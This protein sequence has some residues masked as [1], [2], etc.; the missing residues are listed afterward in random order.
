MVCLMA[1]VKR[2]WLPFPHALAQGGSVISQL[3]TYCLKKLKEDLAAAPAWGGRLAARARETLGELTSG[4]ELQ[5]QMVADIQAIGS[6][7]SLD[8]GKWGSSL[9]G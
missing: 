6:D 4:L 2:H 9:D 7:P 1:L 3:R 8:A 5:R